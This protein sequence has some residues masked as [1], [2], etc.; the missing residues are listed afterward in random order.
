M[1]YLEDIFS[2]AAD[3]SAEAFVVEAEAVPR[4]ANGHRPFTPSLAVRSEILDSF[5]RRKLPL[6][7]HARLDRGETV[8]FQAEVRGA[9]WRLKAQ[10][11]SGCL[12]LIVSPIASENQE[13]LAQPVKLAGQHSA[14][15]KLPPY[16]PKTGSS[17]VLCPPP[18]ALASNQDSASDE[19]QQDR[20]EQMVLG[21]S[22]EVAKS[23]SARNKVFR[24]SRIG[25][26]GFDLGP[27]EPGVPG[28]VEDLPYGLA[29]GPLPLSKNDSHA[30]SL[31]FNPERTLML[32]NRSEVLQAALTHLADP[33]ITICNDSSVFDSYAAIDSLEPR[34]C[35]VVDVEDPS[36]WFA[37][38]MR[39]L[40]QG[41]T[42]LVLCRATS[43]IGALRIFCGLHPELPCSRWLAEHR[44]VF[45][46]S[47]EAVTS[48][49][50]GDSKT[51]V[52]F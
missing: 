31:P 18:Q 30:C 1:C 9:L 28:F 4:W 51:A 47:L 15:L 21:A 3:E 35:V 12:Q 19:R 39:R 41:C 10:S 20:F 13:P 6:G 22:G 45:L 33:T 49:F 5:L 43:E 29:T 37:W 8:E 27:V 36:Q 7:E 50:L 46:P 32:I 16:G 2:A 42:V 44:R 38:V 24:E 17:S 25:A 26:A 23:S 48:L 52:S 34:S 40:E 11:V 14:A